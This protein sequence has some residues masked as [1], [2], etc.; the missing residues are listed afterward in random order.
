MGERCNKISAFIQIAPVAKDHATGCP[1]G[2]RIVKYY[3]YL[4]LLSVPF[5]VAGYTTG[6]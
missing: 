3:L 2:R 5:A 4:D 6:R 1:A